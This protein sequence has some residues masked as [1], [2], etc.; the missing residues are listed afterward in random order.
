MLY[1]NES[2][3]EMDR[4]NIHRADLIALL[5]EALY[6]IDLLAAQ[7]GRSP[8]LRNVMVRE[9]ILALIN[10]LEDEGESA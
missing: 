9:R 5:D 6:T 1:S 7:T 10:Q 3:S 8:R 2:I 4:P